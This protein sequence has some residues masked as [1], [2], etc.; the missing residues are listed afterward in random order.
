MILLIA[1]VSD[2]PLLR[3]TDTR[4][5]PCGTTDAG[6]GNEYWNTVVLSLDV[7]AKVPL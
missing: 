4:I 1:V 3:S 5:L 7:T 2:L 6:C